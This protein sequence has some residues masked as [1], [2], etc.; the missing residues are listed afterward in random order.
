MLGI[1]PIDGVVAV[2]R[3]ASYDFAP[4]HSRRNDFSE[5]FSPKAANENTLRRQGASAKGFDQLRGA[6]LVAGRP[7]AAPEGSQQPSMQQER[8]P[9]PTYAYEPPRPSAAFMAKFA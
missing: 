4:T 1:V 6:W 7:P 3:G 8:K 9:E 5:T 2:G